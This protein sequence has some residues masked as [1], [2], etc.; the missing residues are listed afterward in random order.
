MD[1]LR[2]IWPNRV[3]VIS[4]GHKAYRE[5]VEEACEAIRSQI[6]VSTWTEVP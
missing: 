5:A 3:L 1:D 4:D 6:R 2:S